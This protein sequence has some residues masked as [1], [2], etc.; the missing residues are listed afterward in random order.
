MSK[1]LYI[2]FI[3]LF[4]VAAFAVMPV[5][6]QAAAGDPHY[7]S[8]G[9]GAVARIAPE[10][11]IAV[12]SWGSLSLTNLTTGAKV[13]CRNVIGGLVENP[14]PGGATGP[15]GVGETQSFNPYECQSVAC[16]SGAT[17]GGPGTYLEV[18][19]EGSEVPFPNTGNGTNLRWKSHLLTEGALNRSESEFVVVN[20][21]CHVMTG[22]N[23]KGEPVFGVN[24]SEISKGNNKPSLVTHCCK[25]S[26]PPEVEFDAGS[27]TLTNAK[28]EKGKTEGNLKVLGYAEEEIINVQSG[29]K[30]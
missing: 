17:G 24:V 13:E 18:E 30:S 25:A 26:A 12:I 15:P 7:F 3:S 16:T 21:I 11:K 6:A 10:E 28:G 2:S 8:G 5:A 22:V 9:L 20:V 4:A 27:G 29:A 23:G 14:T 1:K 19:A